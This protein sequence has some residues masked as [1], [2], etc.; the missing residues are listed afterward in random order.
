MFKN[1]NYW[2]IAAII[3]LLIIG[4]AVTLWTAGRQDQV[5][6]E[7]ML[8]KT[9]LAGAGISPDQVVALSGTAADLDSPGY[10]KLKKL[11]AGYRAADPDI[12]FAYL[13]G[14]RAG[15]KHFI[16]VDSEPPES[17]DY[18]PPGDDYPDVPSLITGVFSTGKEIT[19]GPYTDQW[20]TWVSGVVPVP[21][22]ETGK[23]IA[24]FGMDVDARNWNQHMAMAAMPVIAVMIILLILILTFF[25]IHERNKR[26]HHRVNVSDQVARKS[27]ERYRFLFTHAPV[28]IVQLDKKGIIIMAN[29]KFAEI[30]G[31]SLEQLIGF[32]T[33]ARIRNPTFLAAIQD[34]MN[35]KTG[36]FE[37]EYTSVITGKNIILRMITQPLG[38]QESEL[39][40]VI[41][42]FEDIT[43]RKQIEAA[44]EQVSRKL[45]FLN[46]VTFNEIENAIFTLTGYLALEKDYPEEGPVEKYIDSALAS[47][48]VI[49]NSL[50]FAKQYRD[51]GVKPPEWQDVNYAFI[52]GISH[53]DFSSIKRTIRLDNLQIYADPLL[54]KVF[55]TLAG[56][57]LRH[58]KTATEITLGYRKSGDSL[59]LFFG[60]NGMGI[61]DANKE[62]IFNRGYGHQPAMELFLVREILGITGITIRETG[63][64]G[65]GACFEIV[66]PK[67]AYRFPEG[68][69]PTA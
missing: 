47:I 34:A 37:G 36:L 30:L 49:E 50:N 48:K 24:V 42:I 2:L 4:T 26:E 28:G 44:L 61:P 59:I 9:R 5:M 11:M 10:Q 67:G 66:I 17:A 40:G 55:F 7:Q 57:V 53:L 65:L 14:E 25:F 15:G 41:G 6:R 19:G 39:S 23:V 60:D 52:F 31:A 62:K 43:E 68:S 46:Y 51:L 27:E 38:K 33:L 63:T 32:D 18:S 13:I 35:G 20:G 8:I 22:P 1:S 64:F 3:I 12:R 54:E 21:D 69:E 45:T 16:F 29:D 56:N 58:A